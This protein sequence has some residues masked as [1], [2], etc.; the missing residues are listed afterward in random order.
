MIF[1]IRTVGVIHAEL[2]WVLGDGMYRAFCFLELGL[3]KPA[4]F[5]RCALPVGRSENLCMFLY[6]IGGMKGNVFMKMIRH[7]RGYVF[8]GM[9]FPT[10]DMSNSVLIDDSRSVR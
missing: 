7:V 5:D 8:L 4:R 9:G 2:V 1:D 6:G 10:S 3:C